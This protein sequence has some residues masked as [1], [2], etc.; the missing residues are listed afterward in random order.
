MALVLLNTI[1]AQLPVYKDPK[2]PAENRIKDLLKRMT[3]EEKADQLNQLNGGFFT[4]PAA[5][6]PGQMVKMQM[7][8]VGK[9]GSFFNVIGA[10][11]TKAIQEIAVKESRLGIPILFALDVIHGYKTNKSINRKGTKINQSLWQ[12][13]Q[14]GLP[15]LQFLRLG[16]SVSRSARF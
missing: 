3:I 4:G 6:D 10:K 12:D 11:E 14:S 13:L 2:Q 1:Q 15:H 16:V 9:I 5:N 8:R 7:V